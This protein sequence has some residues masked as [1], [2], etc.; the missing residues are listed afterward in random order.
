MSNKET[1]RQQ[2]WRQIVEEQKASGLSHGSFCQERGIKEATLKWWERRFRRAT[3]ASALGEPGIGGSP[4]ESGFIELRTID[5]NTLASYKIRTASGTE[6][7]L[8]GSFNAER[9]QQL[10]RLLGVAVHA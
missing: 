10:L 1:A 9:V 2:H 3:E 5:R 8:S 6:L 4:A 7:E